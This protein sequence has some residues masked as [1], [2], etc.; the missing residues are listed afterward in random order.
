MY[1]LL[2]IHISIINYI[3]VITTKYVKFPTKSFEFKEKGL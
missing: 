2:S 3:Q 1:G